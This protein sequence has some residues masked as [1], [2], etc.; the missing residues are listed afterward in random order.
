MI[1]YYEIYIKLMPKGKTSTFNYVRK[2]SIRR[3]FEEAVKLYCSC[4]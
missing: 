1:S 4:R 3:I 2:Y